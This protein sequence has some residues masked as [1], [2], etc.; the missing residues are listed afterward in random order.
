MNH[1]HASLRP[2]L[3]QMKSHALLLGLGVLLNLVAVASTIGLI[4]LS[5]WFLSASALAGV[6]AA[7]AHS[8]NF[9][10]PSAG[11][12][13]FAITRTAGRYGE[14]ITTHEGTFRLLSRLRRSLFNTIEP[15]SPTQLQRY[16]SSDL[17][18]RLSND[19]DA[20]D[21]LYIRVITPSLVALLAIIGCG[22]V[23]GIFAPAIGMAAAIAMLASGLA[24]PWIAMKK[25]ATPSREWQRLDTE[26]RVYLLERLA[27]LPELLLYGQWSRERETLLSHARQRDQREMTLARLWGASQLL[28]QCLLGLTITGVLAAAAWYARYHELDPTLIAL[29]GLTILAGFEAIA[30]LPR[31]WQELGKMRRAAARIDEIRHTADPIHFPET[32]GT[33]PVDSRLDINELSITLTPGIRTLNAL[34]LTLEAGVHLAL[35]GP[36][37]SGKT[38]LVN[39]LTRFVIPE[40]GH[41]RLGNVALETLS[42]KDLRNSMAVAPQDVHLFM[43]SYRENLR[44]GAPAADDHTFIS[45]LEE[46][47]LG[48]WL[49]EQPEGL[50]SWPDEGGSSLSGGQ[51]RRFGVA[52][53]LLS[54]APIVILDEPTE[55]LDVESERQVMAT[56]Y[57]HTQGRTLLLITHRMTGLDQMDRIAIMQAGSLLEEGTPSALMAD[58]SSR[59]H[60]LQGRVVL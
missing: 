26:G 54:P 15:L 5:G 24:G 42:E 37:G 3:R 25:G 46:L 30:L 35:L 20:L 40:S 23:I 51:L 21:G 31:A 14:R 59:F 47:G 9:F 2:Y 45:L 32:T 52:R 33:Q 36:S 12:R 57:R 44:I 7:T 50:D 55:G 60:T 38:T 43:T 27:G 58:T 53:A 8:F 39:A 29:M 48:S 34:S 49:S 16:G 41:I 13:F 28:N 1:R 56:I 18:T 4:S 22:V 10:L 6:T 17:L 19:I 11:V